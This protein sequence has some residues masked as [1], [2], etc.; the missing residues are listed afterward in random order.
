MIYYQGVVNAFIFTMA[1]L[2]LNSIA[3]LIINIV[4]YI[5]KKRQEKKF[6]EEIE[7]LYEGVR[8]E[9]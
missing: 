6:H 7:K 1:L 3:L 8:D 4:E 2:I 5:I 9:R